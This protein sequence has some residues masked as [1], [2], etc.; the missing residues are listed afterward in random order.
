MIAASALR[1]LVRVPNQSAP[2]FDTA[3]AVFGHTAIT[4]SA[5]GQT[6]T[7]VSESPL[8]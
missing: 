6:R 5:R 3:A 2:G 4:G 1:S 8:W 7:W